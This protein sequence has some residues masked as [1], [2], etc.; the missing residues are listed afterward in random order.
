MCF[1]FKYQ[2]CRYSKSS[3]L[4]PQVRGSVIYVWQVLYEKIQKALDNVF[5]GIFIKE[6]A[7]VAV[8]LGTSKLYSG[9][10]VF[11]GTGRSYM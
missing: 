6:M 5:M 3:F 10:G 8:I 1:L 4:F 9:L 7:T 2:I 11:R